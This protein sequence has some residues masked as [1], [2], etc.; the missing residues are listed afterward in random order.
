MRHIVDLLDAADRPTCIMAVTMENHGPWDVATGNEADPVSSYI[1]HL[2]NGIEAVEML[3]GELNKR[4]CDTL[5]L[6]YGDHTPSLCE[7]GDVLAGG[8]TDYILIDPKHTPERVIERTDQ[9]PE[10]LMETAIQHLDLRYRH[11][12]SPA[13]ELKQS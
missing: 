1:A 3:I 9:R 13:R 6:V 5:M 2:Q 12:S 4:E 8:S 11:L 10:H 7:L